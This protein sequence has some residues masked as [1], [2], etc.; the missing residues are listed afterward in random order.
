[1]FQLIVE[2]V[3]GVAKSLMKTSMTGQEIVTNVQNVVKPVM[4][5]THG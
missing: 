5:N 3:P 2:N 4:I 1:M